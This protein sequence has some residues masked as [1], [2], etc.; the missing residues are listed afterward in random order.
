MITGEVSA[1]REAS[2]R[3]VVRGPDGNGLEIELV[4]DTGF[5]GWISLP[6]SLISDLGLPWHRRGRGELA[7]GSEII[8]DIYEAKIIWDGQ[9]RRVWVD[10]IDSAPLI[11]MSLLD[12]YELLIQVWSGGNVTIAARK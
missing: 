6:S 9:S 8:F 1:N 3:F 7:D 5:N 4:I 12:G 11:G 10:E 2:I